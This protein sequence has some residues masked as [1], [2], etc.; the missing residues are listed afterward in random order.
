MSDWLS[1]DEFEH[2]M[3]VLRDDIRNVQNGVDKIN[4]RV[5]VTETKIAILEDR[6][7]EKSKDPAARWAAVGA[8]AGAIAGALYQLFKG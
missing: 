1:R 6:G 3:H 5:R 8:G 4:G 2:W 7:T